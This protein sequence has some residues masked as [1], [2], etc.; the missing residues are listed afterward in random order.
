MQNQ[1]H[2]KV[3]LWKLGKCILFIKSIPRA[4]KV[5]QA[6]QSSCTCYW[7]LVLV[8]TQSA[9][10]QELPNF[11]HDAAYLENEH[12]LCSVWGKGM[13]DS[14]CPWG[15]GALCLLPVRSSSTEY[16]RSSLGWASR[17]KGER[18]GWT[19]K[20]N[21]VPDLGVHSLHK[22]GHPLSLASFPHWD[23]GDY[24]T[25]PRSHTSLVT[26]LE[27]DIQVFNTSC[28]SPGTDGMPYHFWTGGVWDAGGMG[29]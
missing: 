21:S 6:C 29:Q 26:H 5:S 24:V 15:R 10:R 25:Y 14:E 2:Q 11:L 4:N 17:E 16:V 3:K 27:W 18:E 1:Y 28:Q 8:R 19:C 9:L 22:N 23:S 20:Y 7:F 13:W 12:T